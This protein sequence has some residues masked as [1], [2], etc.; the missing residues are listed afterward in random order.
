MRTRYVYRA[1]VPLLLLLAL[2]GMVI[3]P[4]SATGP[5]I[6]RVDDSF[7]FTAHICRF[8]IIV[9]T[10]LT[11]TETD[12]FDAQGNL[13]RTFLHLRDFGI[14]TNPLSGKSLIES[15]HIHAIVHP[16]ISSSDIGLNF[17]LSLPSGR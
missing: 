12:F 6:Q 15:D 16:D 13:L 11:G 1:A 3:G 14:W 9:P 4:A 2:T 17:H 8:P 7:T 5:E 10:R